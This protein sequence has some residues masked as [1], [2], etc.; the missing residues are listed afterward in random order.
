MHRVDHLPVFLPDTE[1]ADCPFAR[2]IYPSAFP[3]SLENS[4][5]HGSWFRRCVGE[6]FLA[7]PLLGTLLPEFCFTYAKSI[8]QWFHHQLI[9]FKPAHPQKTQIQL[10]SLAVDG[11]DLVV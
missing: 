7:F 8:H 4:Q 5:M 1:T 2:V 6:R 10:P 3:F 11:T 9:V